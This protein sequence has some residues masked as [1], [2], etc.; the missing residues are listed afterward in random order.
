MQT[1]AK[2]LFYYTE[3]SD[4]NDLLH[5]ACYMNNELNIL[6][7]C[8]NVVHNLFSHISSFIAQMT[9]HFLRDFKGK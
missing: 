6:S 1:G 4:V 9:P 3:D 2:W 7:I 5:I 8:Y